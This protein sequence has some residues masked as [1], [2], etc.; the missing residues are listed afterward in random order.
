MG[1]Q[2]EVTAALLQRCWRQHPPAHMRLS[3]TSALH[4]M[5]PTPTPC[6]PSARPTCQ[7]GVQSRAVQ[8][9]NAW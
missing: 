5:T 1:Q 8:H 9:D 7:G 4:S 3:G 6:W 2:H